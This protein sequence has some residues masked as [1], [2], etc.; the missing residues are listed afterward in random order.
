MISHFAEVERVE[1]TELSQQTLWNEQS[2]DVAEALRY[3]REE[4]KLSDDVI[5]KFRF[6]YF[7]Q[8]L[9]KAGHDWAGRLI[10][11]LYDPYGKLVVLTSRD[12]RCKDKMGMPHLHE[13][14]DKKMFLYG[15]DVAK[16]NIIRWQKVIIVEGQ[17]DTAYSHTRGFDVTVGILGSAFSMYHVCV[18][19]RYCSEFFLVFDAD[20]SGYR[21]LARSIRMYK[22]YGLDSFG[23]RFV[24]VL[25][26][27][28]KDPDEFLQKETKEQ[29]TALLTEAKNKTVELGTTAYY[30]LLVKNNP[31]IEEK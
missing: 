21:N 5:K 6:G 10:M 15:V 31:H 3:C 2:D 9:K 30:D 19:A 20:E 23:I 24:P 25:L 1:I 17:F 27:K 22:T 11:P 26:P 13:E 12:F 7:P 8:R 4:R 29:Y 18:L 16:P 28:H 14:F